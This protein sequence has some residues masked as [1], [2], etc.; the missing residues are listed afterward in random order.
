MNPIMATKLEEIKTLATDEKER[1][2]EPQIKKLL[3]I[4]RL[5]DEPPQDSQTDFLMH[6]VEY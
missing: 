2:I 6:N 4:H 3:L 5:A 1:K